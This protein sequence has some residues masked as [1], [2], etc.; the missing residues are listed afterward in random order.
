MSACPLKRVNIENYAPNRSAYDKAQL[1]DYNQKIFG[2]KMYHSPLWPTPRTQY[3]TMMNNRIMSAMNNAPISLP[4]LPV[5]VASASRVNISGVD[6]SGSDL[7]GSDISGAGCPSCK[8]GAHSPSEHVDFSQLG[9]RPTKCDLAFLAPRTQY[10]QAMKARFAECYGECGAGIP[11]V[12]RGYA[13]T[14]SDPDN[15]YSFEIV[16]M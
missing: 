8:R 12:P 3:D 13:S 11:S 16:K 1:D 5:S 9:G 4:E 10:D 14:L 7:S 15:P 2:G 6:L